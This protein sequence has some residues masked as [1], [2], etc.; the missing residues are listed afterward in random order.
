MTE[1]RGKEKRR[2]QRQECDL[3]VEV[4]APNASRRLLGRLYNFSRSGVYF[5]LDRHLAPGV[6]VALEVVEEAG[7]I[8][9]RTCRAAVRWSKEIHAPVV[10]NSHA[11]GAKFTVSPW[12][13][14]G[15]DGLKVI[16]GGVQ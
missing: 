10:L 3:A 8:P 15:A 12:R 16:K 6:E 13:G 9:F 14:K 5:E 4:E 11:A 7:T 1:P 2:H